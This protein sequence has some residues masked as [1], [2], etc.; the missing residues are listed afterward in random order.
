MDSV[1]TWIGILL[2]FEI[3]KFY[4]I[5]T[6]LDYLELPQEMSCLSSLLFCNSWILIYNMI[7]S[8]IARLYFSALHAK[9]VSLFLF[10]LNQ[11]A[12][13]KIEEFLIKQYHSIEI[14]FLS[15]QNSEMWYKR[16]SIAIGEVPACRLVYR[17][18]LTEAN[19]EEIWKS[20]TLSQYVH[21]ILMRLFSVFFLICF[22]ILCIFNFL[23]LHIEI[24]TLHYLQLCCLSNII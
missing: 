1:W 7:W 18:Q 24:S 6:S 23:K 8:L 4:F 15:T 12:N 17:R 14:F 2:H 10:I 21:L 5:A 13:K 3:I 22:I 19:V 11:I 16:H 9:K 20:M